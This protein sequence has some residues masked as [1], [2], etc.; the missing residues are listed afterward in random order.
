MA[1]IIDFNRSKK[2]LQKKW[3]SEI[4]AKLKNREWYIASMEE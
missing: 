3:K 2:R 4:E 1:K